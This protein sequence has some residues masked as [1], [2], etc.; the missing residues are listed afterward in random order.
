MKKANAPK[1]MN[2]EKREPK[3]IAIQPNQF[4]SPF[5]HKKPTLQNS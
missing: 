4:G 5:Q 3:T 1:T 2:K